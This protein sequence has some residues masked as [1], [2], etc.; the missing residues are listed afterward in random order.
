[1]CGFLLPENFEIQD[2]VSIIKN[3]ISLPEQQQQEYR[4]NAYAY[5]RGRYDAGVNYQSFYE[6]VLQ[7][8]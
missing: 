5:W 6:R 7:L 2:A 4:K 8:E 3:Y 1:M